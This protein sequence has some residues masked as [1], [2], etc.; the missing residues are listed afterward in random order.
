MSKPP[1]VVLEDERPAGKGSGKCF[2]CTAKIGERHNEDCVLWKKKV[3]VRATMEYEI[4]IPH[5]WSKE[6]IEFHRNESRWCASNMIQELEQLDDKGC[7]CPH[8][9]FELV[10]EQGNE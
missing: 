6:N 1:I 9:T 7:L 3:T 8:V 4:E 10:K 2:Y 5:F